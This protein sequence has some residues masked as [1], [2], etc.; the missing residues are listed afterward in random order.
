MSWWKKLF[1]TKSRATIIS[2]K[3]H[4]ISRKSLSPEVLK[5]LYRLKSSGYSAYLV[6]GCLRDLLLGLHPKDYDVATNAKP[7]EVRRL[8]YNSRIIGRRFQIVHVYFKED[9]VEVSTFR[10]DSGDDDQAR[11][12]KRGM[13]LR[14]NVFG[15]L[16]EDAFRRDFTINALY[17]NIEDFSLV[18]YVD[19]LSDIKHKCLRMIGDPEQR[20]QEDPV[21]LVRAL[22]LAAKLDLN[23][24]PETEACLLKQK[25]LLRLVS[26]ARLFDET[27]KLFFTGHAQ[28]SWQMLERYQYLD[29]FF[30]ELSRV[31][32]NDPAS[33]HLVQLILE[34]TDQRFK[35][36][37]TLS[38]AF[39][40][41]AMLWPVVK[42]KLQQPSELH[43][44]QHL[45]EVIHETL[46][47]QAEVLQIFKRYQIMIK[48]IWLLQFNLEQRRRNRI[49]RNLYHRFFR[50]GVDLLELRGRVG[51]VD[52]KLVSWWLQMRQAN[53]EQRQKLMQALAKKKT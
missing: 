45:H 48:D 44:F 20:F 41:A 29:A 35:N 39:L 49:Y 16:P 38:P 31:V 8:F 1:K 36:K 7:E 23:I 17:Y 25:S 34:Q 11:V 51:E 4:G 22:R 43:F 33:L 2:R 13:L 12:T 40:L 32:A 6:G 42:H 52:P 30:P 26:S 50:A 9:V 5:V 28:Q 53:P 18:D 47:R 15:S 24:A 3:Q 37:K 21:R 10:A 14:D 19:A 46:V 27:I